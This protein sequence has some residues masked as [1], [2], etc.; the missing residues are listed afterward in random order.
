MEGD[1]SSDDL[2]ISVAVEV[3][4]LALEL[5]LEGGVVFDDAIVDNGDGPEPATGDMRVCV[6]IG[7]RA[8]SRPASM[9]DAVATWGRLVVQNGRPGR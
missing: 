1:E 7:R 4:S 2:G 9:C 3:D 8:M 5:S 6:C